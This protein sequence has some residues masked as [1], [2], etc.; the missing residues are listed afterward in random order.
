MANKCGGEVPDCEAI[1]GN[2][3]RSQCSCKIRSGPERNG[4]GV[5]FVSL[6]DTSR[7]VLCCLERFFEISDRRDRVASSGDLPDSTT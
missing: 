7:A 5:C 1:V 4:C 3:K 2:D 6:C